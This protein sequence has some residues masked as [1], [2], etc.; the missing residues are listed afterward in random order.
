M[1][2]KYGTRSQTVSVFK[3]AVHRWGIVFSGIAVGVSTARSRAHGAV[4]FMNKS[5]ELDLLAYLLFRIGQTNPE[6]WSEIRALDPLGFHESLIK[7]G[8]IKAVAIAD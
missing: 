8:A 6:L 3:D 1:V 7:E 5:L 2:Y 4:V